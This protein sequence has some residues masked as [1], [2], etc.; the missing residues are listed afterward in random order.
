MKRFRSI[1]K[2]WTGLAERPVEWPELELQ[3]T[4][5]FSSYHFFYD[6]CSIEDDKGIVTFY[7]GPREDEYRPRF[8]VVV[9]VMK[10][11]ATICFNNTVRST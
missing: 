7:I 11:L 4:F 8:D 9:V 1:M 2:R 6:S 5:L 3:G 10:Y